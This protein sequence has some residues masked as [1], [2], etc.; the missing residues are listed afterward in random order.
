MA[1]DPIKNYLQSVLGIRGWLRPQNEAAI[2]SHFELQEFDGPLRTER[3]QQEFDL[4]FLHMRSNLSGGNLSRS[5]FEGEA[6]ELFQKMRAAM[7]I[8]DLRTLELEA[9]ADVYEFVT[10]WIQKRLKNKALLILSESPKNHPQDF[11]GQIFETWSPWSLLQNPDRKRE[12][13]TTLQQMTQKFK[14]TRNVVT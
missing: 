11:G 5:Y 12:A 8:Q 2:E 6:W 9:S 13:W 7:K 10:P 14:G 4:I 3:F 1:Q